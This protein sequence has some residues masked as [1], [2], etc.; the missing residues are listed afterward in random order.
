MTLATLHF[1]REFRRVDAIEISGVFDEADVGGPAAQGDTDRVMKTL[2]NPLLLKD[3][4]FL[5]AQGDDTGRDFIGVDGTQ[6][7]G[8][9]YPL[10]DVVSLAAVTAAKNIRLDFAVRP[11]GKGTSHEVIIEITG[12]RQDGTTGRVRHE[13]VDPDVHSGMSARGV[14]LAV[15]RLLGLAGGPPVAPGLYHPEGLLNPAYVVERLKESGTRIR[16]A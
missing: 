8:R 14:A 13:I 9:A 16:R 15:E 11:G 6:W 7:R 3:G 12:E 5:W 1:A 2:P 4:K 10:L